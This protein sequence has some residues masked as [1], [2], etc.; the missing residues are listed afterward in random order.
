MPVLEAQS[1]LRDRLESNPVRFLARDLDDLLDAARHRLATFLDVDPEGLALLPNATSGVSTVLASLRFRP[2][3]ELLTTDHEYNAILNALA[4]TAWRDGAS[5]VG[6]R[7][8]FPIRDPGE[9]TEAILAAVT[10]RTRL[11]VISHVTS[12]TALVLAIAEIVRELDRCGVD[13]LVDGAHAPGMVPLGLRELG[14]AYWTGNG[15]K[16]LCGPK[17]GAILAVREDRRAAIRPLV[18]SNGWNDPRPDR[19][20]YRK[21]FDWLGTD[22]PTPYLALPVA[23]DV[24]ERLDPAGWPGVMAENRRLALAGQAR[25]ANALGIEAPA[26]PE[27]VGSMAALPLALVSPRDT[28][29][30]TLELALAE[31]DRIE[32][33]IAPWPVPAARPAVADPPDQV[34]VRLSAQRYND[35]GDVEAL[36]AALRRRGVSP[37]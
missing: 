25:L 29:A 27:M 4:A 20:T 32:V 1:A 19:S 24:M 35:I 3:D 33:P 15:H 11:A 18:V 8:P 16:W 26:P 22:D 6:A 36:V 10:P 34:V 2:G 28:A 37:G 12:P 14:A 21:E 9:A 7:V 5:V 23:I 13:T 31:E 30:A 17:G